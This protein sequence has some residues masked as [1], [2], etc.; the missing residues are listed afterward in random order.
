MSSTFDHYLATIME[1][2]A[3]EAR[4]AGSATIE[5]EH[6]LL[7]VAA[8]GEATTRQV[9]VSA[10]LDHQAI[11]E[12]LD[13]EFE[14]SLNAAGVSLGAFDLPRPSRAAKLPSQLGAS[15]R[16]VLERMVGTFRKKDLRPAHLLLG[17]LQAE[18]GT[19][20]RALTLAGVDRHA[21]AAQARRTITGQD[22]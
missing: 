5:A 10:G 20:P 12:A 15:A 18:V 21:L 7:A 16:L 9:L 2:G 14:H 8:E 6:L 11:R 1:E 13:R 22:D 17:I 3:R 19:V 4:Q